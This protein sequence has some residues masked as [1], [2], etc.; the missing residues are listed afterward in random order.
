[1]STS[2]TGDTLCYHRILSSTAAVKVC[3]IVLGGISI[4]NSWSEL[5]GQNEDPLLSST[6]ITLSAGTSSIQPTLVILRNLNSLSANGW[7]SA[8][9]GIKWL[10]Q[11]N[12]LPAIGRIIRR[13]GHCRAMLLGTWRRACIYPSDI[14]WGNWGQ[15]TL[16][17][18]TCIGELAGW[19]RHE[20]R[21]KSWA[22]EFRWDFATSAE[23]M[24]HLHVFV[25]SKQVVCLDVLQCRWRSGVYISQTNLSN[26]ENEG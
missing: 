7:K 3:H 23:V 25:M 2:Q 26:Q 20:R 24:K 21:N 6:L 8:E 12:L 19:F 4:G 15:T 16:I 17:S 10:S 18:F 11:R 14:A 22:D 5:F 13:K 1:M 9:F